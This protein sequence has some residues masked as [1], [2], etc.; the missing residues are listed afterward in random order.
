MVSIKWATA[1]APFEKRVVFMLTP[2]GPKVL[3]FNARLGDP[4]TQVVLPRPK[5]IKHHACCCVEL[6]FLV[7]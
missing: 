1:K 3:E 7:R 4:E 2:E 6:F 5:A